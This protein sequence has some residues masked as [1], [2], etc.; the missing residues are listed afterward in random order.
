MSANTERRR[1]EARETTVLPFAGHRPYSVRQLL[2]TDMETQRAFF[3]SLSREARFWRFMGPKDELS[4]ALLKYLSSADGENHVALIAETMVG[5]CRV[6]IA[7]ARYVIDA[8]DPSVAEFALAVADDWQGRGLATDLLC[9]LER[10]AA[11]AGLR[12]MIADTLNGNSAMIALAKKAGYTVALNCR[13]PRA[14]RLSKTIAAP[15]QAAAWIE[16]A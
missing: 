14:M 3:R 13:E 7:E 16:A 11:A 6:M 5:G 1:P 15:Q 12:R 4:E 2:P 8:A 9:R 10:H